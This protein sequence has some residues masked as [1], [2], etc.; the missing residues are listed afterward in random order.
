MNEANPVPGPSSITSSAEVLIDYW[1]S[2]CLDVHNYGGMMH[3]RPLQNTTEHI[4]LS[5]G[6][7]FIFHSHI[8]KGDFTVTNRKL[9]KALQDASSIR[10]SEREAL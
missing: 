1:M 5:H 9:I 10:P 8:I 3:K 2:A 7:L 4:I 6:T